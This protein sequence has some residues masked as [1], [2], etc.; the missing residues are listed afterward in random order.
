VIEHTGNELLELAIRRRHARKWSLARGRRHK[1]CG[2]STIRRVAAWAAGFVRTGR[3]PVRRAAEGVHHIDAVGASRIEPAI[4]HAPVVSVAARAF[5]MKPGREVAQH[6]QASERD[7][8][9]WSSEAINVHA[10]ERWRDRLASRTSSAPCRI[11]R[12]KEQ[13]RTMRTVAKQRYDFLCVLRG[14]SWRVLR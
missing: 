11:E 4:Q 13:R 7:L 9:P 3:S 8:W 14:I 1:I 6:A 2:R 5:Q 12:K 10:K